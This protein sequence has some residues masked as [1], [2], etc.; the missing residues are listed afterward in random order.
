MAQIALGVAGAVIG[1]FT[2]I[3]PAAGWAI[4]SAI[5]ALLF[6]PEQPELIGPRASDLIAN[7]S[8]YGVPVPDIQG[9]ARVAGN[10]IWSSPRREVE[11]TEEQGKGGGGPTIT[12]FTYF[13]SMA[14]L[15]TEGQYLGGSP[16]IGV[17]KIWLDQKLYWSIDDAATAEEIYASNQNIPNVTVYTGTDTQLPDPT[18]EAYLG[19]GNVPGYR[20]LAYIVFTDLPLVEPYFGRRPNV[21][22]EVVKGG[23][24]VGMREITVNATPPYTPKAVIYQSGGLTYT[25]GDGAV[26]LNDLSGNVVGAIPDRTMGVSCDVK[27][28]LLNHSSDPDAPRRVAYGLGFG[29]AAGYDARDDTGVTY[30]IPVGA[31][32]ASHWRPFC[33]VGGIVLDDYVF[34]LFGVTAGDGTNRQLVITSHGRSGGFLAA[35][36][37]GTNDALSHLIAFDEVQQHI[38]IL[39]DSGD[40]H[41]VL[42]IDLVEV[43]NVTWNQSFADRPRFAVHG[44]DVLI[45]ETGIPKTASWYKLDGAYA[46]TLESTATFTSVVSAEAAPRFVSDILVETGYGVM[47]LS[48]AIE[49]TEPTEGELVLH[50]AEQA[51]LAASD[52]DVTA[53]TGPVHGITRSRVIPARQMIQYLMM[54]GWFDF[55]ESGGQL[56]GVKRG[57]ASV[58]TITADDLG[59]HAFGSDFVDALSRTRSQELELPKGYT[60]NHI[61]P[62]ADYQQGSQRQSRTAAQGELEQ[63]VDLPI[64]MTAL[65]GKQIANVLLFAAWNSRER[66]EFAAS[67]KWAALEPCDPITITLPNVTHQVRIVKRNESLGLLKFEGQTEQAAIYTPNATAS[68]STIAQSITV[69]GPTSLD[70]PELPLLQDS[71]DGIAGYAVMDGYLSGWNGAALFRSTDGGTTWAIVGNVSQNAKTGFAVTALG[72]WSGDNTVDEANTV[73]VTMRAGDTLS[74]ITY[75][76][77][78]AD[79][80]ANVF[81]IGSNGSGKWEVIQARTPT[82]LTGTTY[83]LSGLLRG[84]GGT[85]DAMATHAIGDIVLGLG[86]AGTLPIGSAADLGLSRSYE[87]VTVGS[88]LGSGTRKSITHACRTLKPLSPVFPGLG[89]SSGGDLIFTAVRRG[90]ILT[91]WRDYT[92]VP[93]GETSESYEIDIY[94]GS[95]I[96][97]TVTGLTSLT[98][99]YTYAMR[100]ADGLLTTFEARVYQISSAVGRGIPLIVNID[101]AGQHYD[102]LLRFNGTDT[103]TTFTDSSPLAHVV[104]AF[105]SAQIDTAQS[106]FGGAAGLFNGTTDYLQVADHDVWAFGTGDFTVGCA[107]RANALPASNGVLLN[108]WP[109]GSERWTLMINSAGAILWARGGGPVTVVS[110]ANGVISTST[111]YRVEVCRASGTTRLFLDGALLASAADTYDYANVAAPLVV[112]RNPS[113]AWYFNG[114]LDQAYVIKGQALHTAAFTPPASEF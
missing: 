97:R 26:V 14:I 37:S 23:A 91:E 8:Q 47:R 34:V 39:S 2:P 65:K 67:Q 96:I 60:V 38:H 87:A 40:K 103:S 95:T 100:Q 16:I 63:I 70:L 20:G 5:G 31:I 98:W 109:A 64:A 52:L 9:T 46:H 4:G 1:S 111:W 58:A 42:D 108:V 88:T 24:V 73:D 71:D 54:Y 6:P 15:L 18:I 53:L 25:Q 50:Y 33:D 90:R 86:M 92:D 43:A 106:L 69:A 44:N 57:G 10:V 19:V 36:G 48:D 113:P 99:T 104:T 94:N 12:T 59:A 45:V 76:A 61:E 102:L 105:G 114:W 29:C 68:A 81:A 79:P 77:M 30:T 80:T 78:L 13:I 101:V 17:R 89:I 11:T 35:W 32:G 22:C 75:D 51:G 107:L 3:G 112:G 83:R 56:V 27:L 110:S 84:R 41:I 7:T 49:I 85:E 72:T 28:P 93:I 21:S 74:S 82:L 62:A 55:R 66:V